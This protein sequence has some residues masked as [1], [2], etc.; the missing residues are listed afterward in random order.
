MGPAVGD[1]TVAQAAMLADGVTEVKVALLG[2]QTTVTL[3][4]LTKD[5]KQVDGTFT[6]RLP[7]IDDDLKIARIK[8]GLANGPWVQLSPDDQALIT[9]YA[10]C[11][12]RVVDGPDWWKNARLTELR[13]E[14]PLTLS[15]LMDVH[16]AQFFRGDKAEDG[17]TTPRQV[18]VVVRGVG[19]N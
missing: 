17:T 2:E 11:V 16:E 18:V 8:A 3:K 7:T 13:K 19:E 14:L 10:K 12:I 6:I 1:M 9:A 15:D 5:G 4:Y